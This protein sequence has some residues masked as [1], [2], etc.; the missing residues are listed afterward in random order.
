MNYGQLKTL[1][2]QYLESSETSFLANMPQFVINAEEEIMR[3]VQ[4]QDLM[5]TSTAP[6][7]TGTP[8]VALP[9]DFLSPYSLFVTVAG[10]REALLSKDHSFISEYWP[11]PT[12]LG[13]PRYYALFDS[14]TMLLAPTPD[15]TYF[16]EM[17][18]YY[19]PTSLTAEVAGDAA[20]T[21]ISTYGENAILFGTILQGY[22]YL[23]GDQD[24]IKMYQDKFAQAINDLK[25]IAEGRNRKDVYRRPDQKVPT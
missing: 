16:L 6:V 22:I 14:N 17:N 25:V 9:D 24:V 5:Q 7:I 15:T 2:S 21:G 20:T 23:K 10:K 13:T 11:D 18:Y 12:V 4:L 19:E 8:Y 1:V 3:Q